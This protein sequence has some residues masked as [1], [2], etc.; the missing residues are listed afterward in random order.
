L[1]GVAVLGLAVALP[2]WLSG[3]RSNPQP[4]A[5][6][7]VTPQ[8][9]QLMMQRAADGLAA[10]DLIMSLEFPADGTNS[11]QLERLT[12]PTAGGRILFQTD[13]LDSLPGATDELIYMEDGDPHGLFV[14]HNE[15]QYSQRVGE[16]NL[17]RGVMGY[18]EPFDDLDPSADGLLGQLMS[19][20][21]LIESVATAG[22]DKA[23]Q[24]YITVLGP[25]QQDGR[26][27]VRLGLT[28]DVLPPEYATFGVTSAELWLYLDDA[29]PARLAFDFDLTALRRVIGGQSDSGLDQAAQLRLYS[30]TGSKC[31][32]DAYDES[33]SGICTARPFIFRW[34]NSSD[35][36]TA[37]TL[38][39]PDGY[40]RQPADTENPDD[41]PDPA[42]RQLIPPGN[43]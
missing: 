39:I 17:A 25:D 22:A 32:E 6:A 9:A 31:A 38:E 27:V 29:M 20:W 15:R 24:D 19:D 7:D 3:Q 11:P 26:D 18:S 34:S 14:Y 43:S 37:V 28:L 30:A 33:A 2:L 41:T 1:A 36:A 10:P 23:N 42:D 5:A 8:Y 13:S 21:R 12:A 16:D 40:T 4:I 35:P